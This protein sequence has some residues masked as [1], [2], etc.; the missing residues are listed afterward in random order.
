[1]TK[2]RITRLNGSMG[3]GTD[4]GRTTVLTDGGLTEPLGTSCA[5]RASEKHNDRTPSGKIRNFRLGLVFKRLAFLGHETKTVRTWAFN[6][7]GAPRPCQRSGFN[8]SQRHLV[9]MSI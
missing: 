7:P 6:Q 9:A 8:L 5:R 4:F 2:A 3:S 1:M